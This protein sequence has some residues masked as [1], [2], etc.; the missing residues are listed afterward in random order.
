MSNHTNT[1][2]E[3]GYVAAYAGTGSV[4][5][6][7]ART[8]EH[9]NAYAAAAVCG[10]TPRARWGTGSGAIQWVTAETPDRVF[11]TA[12]EA[13]AEGR[14]VCKR[15]A[16][17]AAKT[18]AATVT[19]EPAPVEAAAPAATRETHD[20]RAGWQFVSAS[21]EDSGHSPARADWSD[22]DIF[23][24]V[25]DYHVAGLDA[26]KLPAPADIRA[27]EL[28]VMSAPGATRVDTGR[29]I[30]PA[31]DGGAVATVT[32]YFQ[33]GPG[34]GECV[35][36]VIVTVAGGHSHPAR[37]SAAHDALERLQGRVSGNI[38]AG[39]YQTI[40]RG[41]RGTVFVFG[42]WSN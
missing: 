9:F 25:A 35:D 34:R 37:V 4:R 21:Y 32:A 3:F 7:V 10:T 26:V 19:P 2:A 11:A 1:P 39:E 22:A 27:T 14:N 16:A 17:A 12:P 29:E 6:V 38:T 31:E 28:A 8:G 5:H 13:A 15:C 18:A 41:S 36:A 42:T 20:I 24:F 23:Q 33:G 40:A 30:A